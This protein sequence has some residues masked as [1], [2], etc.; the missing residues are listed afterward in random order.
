MEKSKFML[1]AYGTG[2]SVAEIG[3]Q[4]AW[5][6]AAL[7]SSPYEVGVGSCTPSV[8]CQSQ[9]GPRRNSVYIA[10]FKIDFQVEKPLTQGKSGNGQCWQDMF[11]NPLAVSGYPILRRVEFGSGLEIPLNAIVALAQTKW[12]DTFDGKLFIKGF[13]TMLVPTKRSGDILIW[14]HLFHKDGSRI[15]YLDANLL[16]VESVSSSTLEQVRHVVGWHSD[17]KSYA[18]ETHLQPKIK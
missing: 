3:Q 18:G 5:L 2:A 12:V 9:P 10:R 7:R 8:L 11:R 16:H 14:H 17:V 1:E 13:S 6:G 15:S 4:L